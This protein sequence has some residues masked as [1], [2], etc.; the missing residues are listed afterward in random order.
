MKAI[1]IATYVLVI[2]LII[3]FCWGVEWLRWSTFIHFTHTNINFW[4]WILLNWR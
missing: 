1:K 4:S 2:A 3:T